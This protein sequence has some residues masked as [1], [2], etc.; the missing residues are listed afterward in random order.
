MVFLVVAVLLSLAGRVG[1]LDLDLVNGDVVWA[2]LA[3]SVLYA[4]VLTLASLVVEEFSFRRHRGARDLAIACW[5]A[6]EENVGYRQLNAWWRM[7]GALDA[8]RRTTPVWGEMQR[9]GLG[10]E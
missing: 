5:S 9:R 2:L 10:R 4:I 7:R 3:S 6:V 1:L 8:W